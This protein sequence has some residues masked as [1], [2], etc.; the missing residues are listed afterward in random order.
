[1]LTGG[2]LFL[3]STS[4][5]MGSSHSYVSDPST[6]ATEFKGIDDKDWKA[7]DYVIV[8]GG[9][10]RGIMIEYSHMNGSPM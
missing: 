5:A 6:F 2:L 9:K 4:L 7:Y 1:V 10:F 3:G 8:G